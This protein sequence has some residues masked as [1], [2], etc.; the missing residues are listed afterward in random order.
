MVEGQILVVPDG[1]K[2]SERPIIR[3]Q[4]FLASG[5][6]TFSSFGFTWPIRGAITQFASWYHMAL[7]IAAPLGTP[8]VAAHSGVVSNIITGTWDGGYGTNVYVKNGDVESHSQNL[9][10]CR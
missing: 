6:T 9:H 7:D 8:I 10:A 3:R 1:I 2:P 4:V 5:P